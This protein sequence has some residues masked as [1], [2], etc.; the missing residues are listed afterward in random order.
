MI[1]D[2]QTNVVYLSSLLKSDSR[3]TKTCN[4]ITT[5]LES[6]KIPFKFLESTNDIWAR[7]YMPI[8][9]SKNRFIEYRY[10]PDYLQ[11]L[12]PDQRD[13][14][15]Y[16]DLVCE[17]III[18]TAKSNIILDGGNVIKS[19]N[20]VILTDKIFEENKKHYDRTQLID[21][22]K[23]L[24]EVDKIVIIPWD[25][26]E[27]Y[28]H[29]DGMIRFIDDLTVLINGYFRE[30]SKRFEK[31]FFGSLEQNGLEYCE[32]TYN[33]PNPNEK[34][35]WA[36]INF[37]HT[38]DLIIVPKFGIE[39]DQ[40]AFDQIKNYFPEY[41]NQNRICQV[42]MNETAKYDGALNCISW[43]VLE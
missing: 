8:Q 27:P 11:G 30:I 18:E 32:L 17:S 21:K 4:E 2:N 36:Y 22:L 31:E 35:N 10:D 23:E 40:Q 38:K 26:S 5:I 6:F 43:T 1:A 24:F 12:K 14:K 19:T 41:S 13:L 34:L 37:L 20:C 25:K 3:Y 42:D 29:A 33:V 16:P 15:T 9:L 28:G 39:E 7:D